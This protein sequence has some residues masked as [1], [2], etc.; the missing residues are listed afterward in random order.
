MTAPVRL[1]DKTDESAI[2]ERAVLISFRTD[3]EREI[4][5]GLPGYSIRRVNPDD[6]LQHTFQLQSEEELVILDCQSVDMEILDAVGWLQS[7]SP[8]PLLIFTETGS[9]DTAQSALRMGASA[10]VVDGCL[11]HRILPIAAVAM[12]RFRQTHAI[13]TELSKT[14]AILAARKV[15]DRAKGVLMSGKG[16]S[17]AEA[18]DFLRKTAMKQ[19]KKVHEVAEHVLS[20]SELL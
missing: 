5:E 17:E 19:S 11:S 15:I 7:A 4:R 2:V 8:C 16:M 14:R 1:S 9:A 12:E 3:H 20:L 6:F 10:C 18:Y 13:Q